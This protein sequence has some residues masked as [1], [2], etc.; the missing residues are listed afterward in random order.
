[1]RFASTMLLLVGC[2]ATLGPSRG[3]TQ[4]KMSGTATLVFTNATAQPVCALHMTL[5]GEREYGDNWLAANLPSGKSVDFKVAAGKYKITW[6]TCAEQG[7]PY[8][9]GTLWRDTSFVVKDKTQLYAYV[10]STVAPTRYAMPRDN[11]NVVKF[12]GQVVDPDPKARLAEEER[13]AALAAMAPPPPP[14]ATKEPVKADT[15]FKA[16]DWIDPKARVAKGNKGKPAIKPSLK[17]SHDI[18]EAKVN[19]RSK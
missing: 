9:A 10:A 7:K 16:R 13:A 6:N 1:M 15:A 12:P 19:Y 18:V 3:V 8:L 14:A 17:R 2:Q 11:Y 5:D 4:Q